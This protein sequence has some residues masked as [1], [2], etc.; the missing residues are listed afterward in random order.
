MSMN[1]NT[2]VSATM[3]AV[4]IRACAKCGGKREQDK[5]C[6][7]CGN[8]KSPVVH[9]LGVQAAWYRDPIKNLRWLLSGQHKAAQRAELA[10]REVRE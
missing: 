6:A 2:P 5:P 8:E 3:S 4:I 10:N 1:A 9:E 7:T